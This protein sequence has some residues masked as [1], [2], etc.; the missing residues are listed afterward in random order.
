MLA[1]FNL[2][3]K[4]WGEA[5]NTACYL[6]N[7]LPSSSIDT[8]PYE[9]W[10]REKPK[11]DQLKVFGCK[12]MV[13]IP[14]EKRRKLD[15][16][17]RALFF[18]GYAEN[19]KGWRF[20]D[21]ST[22]K[23]IISRDAKFFEEELY[24]KKSD[25]VVNKKP[26]QSVVFEKSISEGEENDETL[27][28]N[29]SDE[30]NVD[31]DGD[32]TLVNE[33]E[34]ILENV[35]TSPEPPLVRESESEDEDPVIERRVSN[36]EKKGVPPVRYGQ[37]T[38][39]VQMSDDPKE[40]K[41]FQEAMSSPEKLKWMEAMDEEMKSQKEN[42]TWDLVEL[43]NGKK[44]VGCKWV[45]KIKRNASGE[46]VK[47]KARLV[48][49]GFTQKFGVDYD[50]VF[51]PVTR[52]TTLRV[53]LGIAS[54][55]KLIL[56]HFDVK[57]AYLCG[58]LDEEIFMRQPR[59]YQQ[60][61]LVCKLKKSLYGLKQSAR[62][63]NKKLHDV[64]ISLKFQQSSADPCLYTKQV[65]GKLMYLL[66]YVDDLLIAFDEEKEI[67]RLLEELQRNLPIISLGDAKQFLGLQIKKEKGNYS[68]CL[69]GYIEKIAKKF[70]L[71]D[72][73][74]S[75]IP[76]DTG[77]VRSQTET[78]KFDDP[79]MYQ[80]IIGALLYIAVN[81]RPDIAVSTSILAR[82]VSCPSNSDWIAAKRV[83]RYLVGTKD[84]KL[85][86]GGAGSSET[87]VGYSDADWAGDQT[88]SKSNTG[89]VFLYNGGAVSWASRKQ[90]CVTLSSM[91]AEYVALSEACQEVVWL[92]ELFEELGIPQESPTIIHEDNQSC[93]KFV[94]N[95]KMS[96]RSK[97]INTKKNYV[98]ELN[99]S[100]VNLKY[101]PS[102]DMVA[103]CLTKPLPVVKIQKFNNE[104]GLRQ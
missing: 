61:S 89:F 100:T 66:V 76:M 26:E 21:T 72:A 64:L 17:S 27:S 87:L 15:E 45:F 58:N 7:R 73:K 77:F 80:S 104:M 9:K 65:N 63:W 28:Q 34:N 81:A 70:G 53:L 25:I 41:D 24:A 40:P 18:V 47:Y 30:P 32:E 35:E 60:G 51:A 75:Y 31:F 29:S 22:N 92:R 11:Y 84:L 13:H 82:K 85:V 96:K 44:T 59:G 69:R 99:G 83:I 33:N 50:E 43:P 95:E 12:A 103:D 67:S 16:K 36:R 98:K 37:E 79:T 23:I 19:Q 38:K 20:L 42:N 88:D 10:F 57:T 2:E 4:Y 5:T 74:K 102:A 39:K 52:L 71:E 93:I 86:F 1:E 68:I 55:K 78:E 48:A 46:I 94:A 91:E 3:K 14:K 90:N 97:H 101:C 56:K 54:K 49:Q 6:I 62:C 8:T